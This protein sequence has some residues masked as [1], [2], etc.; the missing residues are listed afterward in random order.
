MFRKSLSIGLLLAFGFNLVLWPSSSKAALFPLGPALPEPGSMVSLS[1]A[2]QPAI[3]KG[4]TVHRDDPFMFDFIIDVGQDNLSG[5]AL[6]EEGEKLIKYFLTGLAIPENDLWVNLSPYEKDR[7]IPE[8]LSQTDM[9]RDLLAQDYLLKQITAS[10]IYPEKELG[11]NFWDR[12]YAQARQAYRSSD[13]PVNTFNK[14]WIMADKAEVFERNQTAFVVDSHLK[15]MLEEDYLSMQKNATRDHLRGQAS[16]T[17]EIVRTIILPELEKEVNTGTHFA[18]LRQ[19]FNSLILANWYK[20]NLQEAP[21]NQVYSDHSKIRGIDLSDK[22]IKKQIYERYLEAY[23]K[24]VFDYIKED[25]DQGRSIP[26]KYFSGGVKGKI[27]LAMTSHQ[28]TLARSLSGRSLVLFNA[29]VRISAKQGDAAMSGSVVS[30]ESMRERRY[31]VAEFKR[32]F[33]QTFPAVGKKRVSLEKV[34]QLAD[35]LN[36]PALA[37]DKSLR[38]FKQ[39]L[40][41]YILNQTERIEIFSYAAG[42]VNISERE[43]KELLDRLDPAMLRQQVQPEEIEEMIRYAGGYV[44]RLEQWL[45]RPRDFRIEF[46]YAASPSSHLILPSH[47][48]LE[49]FSAEDMTKGID[50]Q[51]YNHVQDPKYSVINEVGYGFKV[52]WQKGELVLSDPMID[53]GHHIFQRFPAWY[54]K[55]WFKPRIPKE[56]YGLD[57]GF[58]P[59]KELQNR[60]YIQDPKFIER[61]IQEARKGI[62]EVGDKV[63]SSGQQFKDFYDGAGNL[64]PEIKP[65]HKL[66]QYFDGERGLPFYQMARLEELDSEGG[67]IDKRFQPRFIFKNATDAAMETTGGIDLKGNQMKLNIRK[68]GRGVQM[69]IDQAMIARL[70]RQGVGRVSPVIF[71]I[72]PISN[73]WPLLGLD[74]PEKSSQ[75]PAS[76]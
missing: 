72:T 75:R 54:K 26:R 38:I 34:A 59:L 9:G 10:L 60:G 33:H 73:I 22:S 64:R 76:G 63:S 50:E 1:P 30:I 5:K 29:G 28:G 39:Q 3:I 44:A 24:G 27:D 19:I 37:G 58:V 12:V 46:E 43:Q 13:V 6:K 61:I 20:K 68:D 21:L 47:V 25:Q 31:Q 35:A 11:K 65:Q 45:K 17:S 74:L 16:K 52:H 71:R 70:K 8:V 4:L 49:S 66:V 62:L 55:L 18:P 53:F 56:Y 36:S 57:V 40:R 23:K 67:Y 41:T 32:I 15:V 42:G 48:H 2:Y 7:T 14:V 51:A 69:S